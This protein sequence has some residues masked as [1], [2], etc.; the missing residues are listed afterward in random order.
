MGD[1]WAALG[2]YRHGLLSASPAR[3]S[4]TVPLIFQP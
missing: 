1:P 3:A 2:R 4:D